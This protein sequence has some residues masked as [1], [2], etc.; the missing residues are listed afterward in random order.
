MEIVLE[1]KMRAKREHIRRHNLEEVVNQYCVTKLTL[2]VQV[3]CH[4]KQTTEKEKNFTCQHKDFAT[5][6][7][8]LNWPH[9]W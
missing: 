2:K 1:M 4:V 5:K 8:L 3:Q 6:Y 9:Q 7:Y